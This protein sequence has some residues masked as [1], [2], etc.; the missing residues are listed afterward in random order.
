VLAEP[1]TGIA[2]GV[3]VFGERL[4]DTPLA[5]TGQIAALVAVAAGM[6]LVSRSQTLGAR[7]H[8]RRSPHYAHGCEGD[9]AT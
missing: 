7:H 6:V 2:L 4:R 3:A 9:D 8:F 5:L 1:L